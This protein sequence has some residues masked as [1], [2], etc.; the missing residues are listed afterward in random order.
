MADLAYNN[1]EADKQRLKDLWARFERLAKGTA[2]KG[3]ELSEFVDAVLADVERKNDLIGAIN[4]AGLDLTDVQ[5]AINS[6]RA[7]R[8]AIEAEFPGAF[9][10]ESA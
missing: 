3:Q 5:G 1:A 10:S 4:A 9:P 8:D 7:I 2:A 6:A